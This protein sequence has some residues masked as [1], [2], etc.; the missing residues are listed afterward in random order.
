MMRLIVVAYIG[1][2]T[3]SLSA[4]A[5]E[6]INCKVEQ[7]TP[8]KKAK[9]LFFIHE[10]TSKKNQ[11]LRTS[12]QQLIKQGD[13]YFKIRDFNHAYDA[14]D[15]ACSNMPSAY[16]Y[17]RQGD[18]VFAPIATKKAFWTDSKKA[19][20]ACFTSEQFIGVAENIINSYWETG[21]ELEK[22]L[23]TPPRVSK[24]MVLDVKRKITCM[25]ALAEHYKQ[26]K[27]ACVDVAKV[28]ACYTGVAANTD[29]KK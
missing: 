20:G 11:S 7:L 28:D 25:R 10:K 17:I 26:T 12:A 14:Y 4:N 27:P 5:E 29:S 24:A 9:C 23:K 6:A 13:H 15:L 1:F 8:K 18:S 21:L 2:C 22:I 19:T 16:G 3:A